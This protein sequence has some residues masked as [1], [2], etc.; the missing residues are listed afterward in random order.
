MKLRLAA[1]CVTSALMMLVV[2]Y[3]VTRWTQRENGKRLLFALKRGDILKSDA[4]LSGSF[5]AKFSDRNGE[6]ALM[7]AARHG[8]FIT[9]MRLIKAGSDINAKDKNGRTVLMYAVIG[10]SLD[11]VKALVKSGCNINVVSPDGCSAMLLAK[12]EFYHGWLP[13]PPEI[14]QTLLSAASAGKEP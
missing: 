4:L 10:R 3:G 5:D 11:C 12:G 1:L 14:E 7:W 13:P 6:S 2:C 8:H 9:V